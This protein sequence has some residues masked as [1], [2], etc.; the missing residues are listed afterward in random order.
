MISSFLFSILLFSMP[1]EPTAEDEVLSEFR[2]IEKGKTEQVDF[3]KNEIL[4]PIMIACTDKAIA[5]SNIFKPTYLSLY[6][7]RNRSFVG[8]FLHA[9]RGADEVSMMMTFKSESDGFHFWD[10]NKHLL[11]SV[12]ADTPWL[13]SKSVSFAKANSQIFKAYRI[14]DDTSFG[15]GP[16][17]GHPF[18]ILNNKTD[19]ATTLF[20]IYPLSEEENL[21]D[22]QKAYACQWNC[23]YEPGRKRMAAAT[24]CGSFI[25]F[26]DLKDLNEPALVCRKGNILPKFVKAKGG[27]V[28]FLPDN[29]YGFI[30]VTGNAHYCVALYWGKRHDD[31]PKDIY[32][33]NLLLIYDWNGKPIRAIKLENIYRA[34]T[35]T[36]DSDTILL[37]RKN[38]TGEF[39]VERLQL[40][41]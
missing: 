28:K 22:T 9:G 23:H 13:I 11:S 24:T 27:T 26:Y 7:Y 14:N 15:T 40:P 5:L 31:F 20:G 6:D 1:A 32:G 37:V 38:S 10:P 17:Q 21:N 12:K 35:I 4:N 16:F 34:I 29:T 2:T 8:H 41:K 3:P 30:D 36:P 33:G 25:A 39:V 19:S 18:A